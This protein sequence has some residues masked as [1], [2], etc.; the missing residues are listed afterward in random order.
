MPQQASGWLKLTQRVVSTSHRKLLATCPWIIQ[1]GD[2]EEQLQAHAARSR[3]HETRSNSP[4]AGVR[5]ILNCHH[6][7]FY[8]TQQI[9]HLCP[10]LDD[11]RRSDEECRR[12][13]GLK[14]RAG[15]WNVQHDYCLWITAR[16]TQD[17]RI[18]GAIH[19]RH[20]QTA[21]HEYKAAYNVSAFMTL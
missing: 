12:T 17:D 14:A 3:K 8:E 16:T 9:L 1:Q 2:Q 5:L 18:Y 4:A 6:I 11:S 20:L 7:R 13:I 19:A 21:Y 15:T 10:G